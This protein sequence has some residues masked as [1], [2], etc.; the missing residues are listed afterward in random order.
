M[1]EFHDGERIIPDPLDERDE[2]FLSTMHEGNKTPIGPWQQPVIDRDD[3]KDRRVLP[4][5]WGEPDNLVDIDTALQYE[6]TMDRWDLAFPIKDR[7]EDDTEEIAF[8]DLDDVRDP[9][10]GDLHPKAEEIING[11]GSYAQVSTSGTGA[12]V[13]ILAPEG[14]DA[15]T[16]EDDLPDHPDFPHAEIE[17]YDSGR[18]IAFTGDHIEGTPTEVRERQKW[19]NDLEDEFTTEAAGKPDGLSSI[20]EEFYPD[21]HFDDLDVV[22]DLDEYYEAI[23]RVRP[24]DIRLKSTVTNE[25]SDGTKS[26]DPSWERSESG[27]RLAQT[28]DGF[29]YRKGMH[30]LTC[31]HLVALEE[32]IVSDP[33]RYPD[34]DDFAEAVDALR[35]RGASIP[36]YEPAAGPSG[37]ALASVPDVSIDPGSEVDDP[38]SQRDL[39]GL[40]L[41]EIKRVMRDQDRAVIDAIMSGGKTYGSIKAAADL[42]QPAAYFA[43]RLD[44]YDQAEAYAKEVGI[45]SDEIL[46]LPSIKRDCPTWQGQHGDKWEQKVKALYY[47]G[48]QPKTIHTLLDGIPCSHDDD[49]CPY[50]RLWEFDPDDYQLIIGHYKHAHLPIV[51]GGRHLIFDEEVADAFSSRLAGDELAQS[52]N[53]FLSFSESP[54]VDSFDGAIRRENRDEVLAWFDRPEW[55]WEPDQRNVIRRARR[56]PDGQPDYHALAPHALYAMYEAESVDPD[57]PDYPFRLATLP[58]AN[59]RALHFATSEQEGERYVEIRQTPDLTYAQSVCALDGTPLTRDLSTGRTVPAEWQRALGVDL[60]HRRVLQDEA[61]AQYLRDTLNH[62]YIQ[63]SPYVKPYSSGRYANP[64]EDAALLHAVRERIGDGQPPLVFTPKSVADAYMD[65]GFVDDGLASEFNWPGNLRGTDQYSSERLLVQLGSTHH[66][67]HELRRRSAWL[68]EPIYPEGKGTDRT[69]GSDVGDAIYE[70]MAEAQTLQ[71]VLR[72][73]R[74]GDGA[75]VV[76]H[77]SVFP[78][79]LPVADRGAVDLWPDGARAIIEHADRIWPAEP[80]EHVTVSQIVDLFADTGHD[81][82]PQHVRRMLR[83]LAGAGLVSQRDHPDDGRV[84]VYVDTGITDIEVESAADIDIPDDH[85]FT[86]TETVETPTIDVLLS[87]RGM[88]GFRLSDSPDRPP[89]DA[90]ADD[91]DPPPGDSG[92]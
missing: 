86:E 34:G 27:T 28:D 76:L 20:E 45:P 71:N 19:L 32:R 10:T 67:D 65:M 48:V 2:W 5:R 75:V 15:K 54:P 72:V 11:A 77:T 52:I 58:G 56:S 33:T 55:D 73:G 21:E 69:Y 9:A 12:H 92:D 44:L 59:D 41:D 68:R 26:L 49:P 25:R 29:V 66:G 90:S 17:V 80:G 84:N 89:G 53:T 24:R 42:D 81:Y 7:D 82:T 91:S 6:R 88:F 37:A 8:I 4:L 38:L 61:R 57:N 39:Q 16:I 83:R 51:T 50:E 36:K 87:I 78:D 14:L 63:T 40:V 18:Y 30:G 3:D 62:T 1:R 79:W 64:Q 31:L 85:P 60:E 47:A 74:D 70:Q 46:V 35:D 23:H 22:R 13:L 43:P